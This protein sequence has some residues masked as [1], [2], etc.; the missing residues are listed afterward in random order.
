MT[1]HDLAGKHEAAGIDL[2]G[3]GGV[4]RAQIVGGDDQPV[5]T[6]WPKP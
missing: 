3:A 6:A 5:G 4:R 1:G 2:S